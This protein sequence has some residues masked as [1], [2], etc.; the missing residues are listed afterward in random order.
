M[1]ALLA[2]ETA[3]LDFV[4]RAARHDA[5][6]FDRHRRRGALSPAS[7]P[8]FEQRQLSTKALWSRHSLTFCKCGRMTLADAGAGECWPDALHKLPHF[9]AII[10]LCPPPSSL[11][12]IRPNPRRSKKGVFVEREHM[13]ARVLP[14]GSCSLVL[15]SR[16]LGS[17]RV[18]LRQGNG[19]SLPK[20]C[21]FWSGRQ[22]L[23]DYLQ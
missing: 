13:L 2:G 14:L 21:V 3:A 12:D 15:C 20:P 22:N 19:G 18:E 9:L 4:V 10:P 1:K 16:T 17:I 7:L 8:L 6:S 11:S 5:T 23:F